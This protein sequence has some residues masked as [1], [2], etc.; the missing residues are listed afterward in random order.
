LRLGRVLCLLCLAPSVIGMV[1]CRPADDDVLVVLEPAREIFLEEPD[2]LPLG[3]PGYLA[4]ANNGFFYLSDA[5]NHRIVGYD[6]EGTARGT[7]GRAGQG[8]GEFT[9]AGFVAL[10]GDTL[11]AMDHASRQMFLFDRT[12]G[13]LLRSVGMPGHQLYSASVDGD[14]A[15]LG[16]IGALDQGDFRAVVKWDLATDSLTTLLQAPPEYHAISPSPLWIFA[17]AYLTAWNDTLAVL[18]GARNTLELFSGDGTPLAT[19]ELPVRHRRG[20]PEDRKRVLTQP[21]AKEIP[22]LTYEAVQGSFSSP[23]AI[24]RL[25]EGTIAMVHADQTAR[26]GLVTAQLWLTLLSLDGR[27]SCTDRLIPVSS[28]GRP[29]ITMVRDSLYVVDQVIQEGDARTRLRV[30]PVHDRGCPESWTHA[31]DA[32]E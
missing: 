1:A 19:I 22:T 16:L 6:P 21:T 27:R 7:F 20:V 18:F 29:A 3:M 17:S 32:R 24:S 26:R 28:E 13:D 15:W 14:I 31:T 10:I 25:P 9:G 23:R 11:A 5:M 30:F 2:S 8:P 12:T 4:V